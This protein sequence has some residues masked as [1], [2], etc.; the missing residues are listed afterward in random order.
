M[1]AYSVAQ[2]LVEVYGLK[3][4]QR[5]DIRVYYVNMTIG[6]RLGRGRCLYSTILQ[7]HMKDV[8]AA[9]SEYPVKPE[10]PL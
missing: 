9:L 3:V 5:G 2:V 1:H 6:I 4:L 10:V 8:I 7:R